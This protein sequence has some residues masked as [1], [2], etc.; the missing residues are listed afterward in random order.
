VLVASH[1]RYFLDR[2]TE[3]TLEVDSAKATS[4]AGNYTVYP[5]SVTAVQ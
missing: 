2:V 5:E 3:R 1:D 4:Y